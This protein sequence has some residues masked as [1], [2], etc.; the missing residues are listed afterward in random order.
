M[1]HLLWLL[2]RK[3]TLSSYTGETKMK[4]PGFRSIFVGIRFPIFFK[5]N[6]SKKY[7][8]TGAMARTT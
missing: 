1:S 5:K 4:Y 7:K 2:S 3:S 6:I 8:T